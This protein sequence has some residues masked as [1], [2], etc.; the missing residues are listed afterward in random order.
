MRRLLVPEP[1]TILRGRLEQ[2]TRVIA[3]L[4][5][6]AAKLRELARCQGFPDDYVLTGTKTNQVA[7]IGNS[8]CPHVVEALVRANVELEA[9]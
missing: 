4:R 8:V 1:A 3:I 9:A 7:R 5:A 6:R 2:I